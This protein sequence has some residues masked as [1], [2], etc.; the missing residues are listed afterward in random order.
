MCVRAHRC[1]CNNPAERT[2]AQLYYL[3]R[4]HPSTQSIISLI[5]KFG[6][7]ERTAISNKGKSFLMG[8]KVLC[9]SGME[10]NKKKI[11]PCPD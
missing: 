4:E 1:T 8:L 9:R 3:I 6:D 2:T 7:V 10:T 5:A 11:D